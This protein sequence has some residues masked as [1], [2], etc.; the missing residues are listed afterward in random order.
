MK[1]MTPTSPIAEADPRAME[2][3]P[4]R[5][6]DELRREAASDSARGPERSPERERR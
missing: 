2:R 4:D 5:P 6:F 1:E 3:L